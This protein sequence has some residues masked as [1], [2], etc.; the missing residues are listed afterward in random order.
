MTPPQGTSQP[1]QFYQ[2]NRANNF[3][4]IPFNCLQKQT[5]NI[6]KSKSLT[7]HVPQYQNIRKHNKK[8]CKTSVVKDGI[9]TNIHPSRPGLFKLLSIIVFVQMPP[10]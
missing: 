7:A 6:L 3:P 8:Y 2:I 4:E 9:P 1:Q 5:L 10:F